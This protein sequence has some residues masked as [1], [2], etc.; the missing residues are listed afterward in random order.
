MVVILGFS[1]Q[2]PAFFTPALTGALSAAVVLLLLLLVVFY[3]WR[4]VHLLTI[5]Y[6]MTEFNLQGFRI[7]I[8]DLKILFPER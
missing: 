4:Q 2:L 5:I 8:I 7:Y 6:F 1:Q 3:K